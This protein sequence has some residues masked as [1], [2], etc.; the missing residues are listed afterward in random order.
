MEKIMTEKNKNLGTAGIVID[1]IKQI[2]TQEV[3][4]FI[5]KETCYQKGV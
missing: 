3:F 2:I 4:F 1:F 5:N